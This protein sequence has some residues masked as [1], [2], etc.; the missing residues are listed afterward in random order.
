[1][2]NQILKLFGQ[3]S[4][5]HLSPEEFR[6]KLESEGGEVIDVRT[7][8][9]YRQGHLKIASKNLDVTNGFASKAEKLDKEKNYFLYCRS[10][11]RSGRACRTMEEMGFQHV[12]NVGS[13]DELSRNGF[14]IK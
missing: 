1:M 11:N 4:S 2:L 3:S 10:G 7:E 13:I 6:N 5:D 9:E 12:Y 14:D 8:S